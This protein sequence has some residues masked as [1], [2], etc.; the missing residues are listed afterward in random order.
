[1]QGNLAAKNRKSL[2]FFEFLGSMFLTV[3]YRILLQYLKLK[4]YSTIEIE[5]N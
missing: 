1:M 5:N 3:L 4:L 2:F